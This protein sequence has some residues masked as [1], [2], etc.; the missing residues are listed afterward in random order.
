[1]SPLTGRPPGDPILVT[2]S[3]RSGTTWVGR[4]LEASRELEYV[5][6]PFNASLWPRP[7]GMRLGGHYAYV[8][9]ANEEALGAAMRRVLAYRPPYL[10]QLPE[11]RGPRD[12]ARL[13]KAVL[14]AERA[15][16]RRRRPLL[17]DPIAI[18][19]AP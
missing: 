2:G 15:R 8:S 18:F 7:L 6:E 12:V 16:L 19:A 17:K 13:G 14:L 9:E 1:M 5:H 10:R 3:N 11:A 4:M